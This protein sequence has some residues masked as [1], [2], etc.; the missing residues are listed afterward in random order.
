VSHVWSFHLNVRTKAQLQSR[1]AQ[2]RFAFSAQLVPSGEGQMPGTLPGIY[3]IAQGH[4]TQ[5][6]QKEL[7][8]VPGP[9]GAG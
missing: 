3:L 5:L 1:V 2:N 6:E 8:C 4:I 9:A 7:E